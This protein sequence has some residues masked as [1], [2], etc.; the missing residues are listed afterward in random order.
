[1]DLK[2]VY[3]SLGFL[4]CTLTGLRAH[5]QQTS[6][7]LARDNST[8]ALEPYAPK[9][10]SPREFHPGALSELYMNLSAHTAPTMEPRRSPICQ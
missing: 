5:S 2:R 4:I 1:M 10:S 3:L 6:L 7:V 8:I 9:V